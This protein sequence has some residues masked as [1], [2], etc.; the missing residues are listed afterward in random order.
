[1]KFQGRSLHIKRMDHQS[2]KQGFEILAL[3]SDSGYIH[4]FKFISNKHGIESVNRGLKIATEEL[5]IK[6]RPTKAAVYDMAY[7]MQQRQPD[8]HCIYLDNRFTDMPLA[9]ALQEINIG[10][11]GTVRTN[12]SGLPPVICALRDHQILPGYNEVC[13]KVVSD[14]L[15]M[16]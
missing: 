12:A 13:A 2:C 14:V 4:D 16:A 8:M 1:M 11:A 6:L 3:A 10:I 15:C 9:I 7:S 5:H